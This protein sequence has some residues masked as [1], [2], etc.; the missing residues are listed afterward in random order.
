[1]DSK[2]LFNKEECHLIQGAIFEVYRDLG[3]GF[4]EPVYQECLEREF[5]NRKVPYQSQKQ[6]TISYKGEVLAQVFRVDFVCFE[7]ILV[8]L[9]A[10]KDV[11]DEHRAQ[12][13]NYLKV[14]GYRLG[15]LVNYG[16]YPRATVESI[17]M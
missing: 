6:F 1:M 16:H 7:K 10:V 13:I 17:I 11:N 8:E 12:T 15:L 3:A 2:Q 9:I 4:I 5:C 14:S